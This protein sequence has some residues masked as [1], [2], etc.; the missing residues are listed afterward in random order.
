MKNLQFALEVLLRVRTR[1]CFNIYGPKEDCAYWKKCEKTISSL[2]S[3][4]SVTYNGEVR[5]DDVVRSIGGNDLFFLPTCGENFGHVIFEALDAGMPVLISD[6]TPWVDLEEA[7][8]GWAIPL[9]NL[10]KYVDVIH[11]VS[12]W[13]ADKFA[14]VNGRAKAYARAR[15]EEPN[16]LFA[17]RVL[18]LAASEQRF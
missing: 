8:V 1:V 11:E 6:R 7:K 13:G 18:F 14:D 9:D 4:I 2:P 15:A 5:H 3:N 12:G 16:A 10:Q 17:N